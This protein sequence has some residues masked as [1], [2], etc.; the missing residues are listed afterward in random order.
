M[1]VLKAMIKNVKFTSLTIVVAT[2]LSI[3][4]QLIAMAPENSGPNPWKQYRSP[5]AGFELRY[6]QDW[7]FF[8][9]GKEKSWVVSFVSP[10]VFDRDVFLAAKIT[11]CSNPREDRFP[12][13]ECQERDSHLSDMYKDKVRNKGVRS[14]R[15]LNIET[16]ETEDRYGQNVFYYA[17]FS[18]HGRRYFVRGDFTKSFGLDRYVLVFDEM[19]AGIRVFTARPIEIFKNASYSFS[20][21]YPDSWQQCLPLRNGEEPNDEQELLRLVP[22]NQSCSGSNV[23]TISRSAKLSGKTVTGL[24]LQEMLTKMGLTPIKSSWSGY[25]LAQGERRTETQLA[26]ESYAFINRL[27]TRDLLRMSERYE[28]TE[29]LVQEEGREIPL[30]LNDTP[31]Y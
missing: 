30:T 18:S 31:P 28:M 10:E 19:L 2:S 26:R 5:M 17:H 9:R 12:Q 29:K 27:S 14:I 8:D 20:L 16:R 25:M 11:V 22:I 4:W 15:G 7:K 23:I 6:P 21:T 13:G 24:Q 1:T 3:P